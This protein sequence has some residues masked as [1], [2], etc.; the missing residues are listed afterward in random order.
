MLGRINIAMTTGQIAGCKNMKE[1]I[2]FS[3]SKSDCSRG[4]THG[5]VPYITRETGI[6]S[7]MTAAVYIRQV[8]YPA[9]NQC[10]PT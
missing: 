2:S 7:S 10:T 6:L 9:D 5:I 8:M 3:A 1:D 4:I